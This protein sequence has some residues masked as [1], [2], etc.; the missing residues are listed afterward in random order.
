MEAASPESR[1]SSAARISAIRQ[2]QRA[3]SEET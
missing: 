1:S 2:Q 3:R